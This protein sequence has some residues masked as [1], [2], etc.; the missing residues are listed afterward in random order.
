[1]ILKSQSMWF[2]M[3]AMMETAQIWTRDKIENNDTSL[4]INPSAPLIIQVGDFGYE[5]QSC[6][7]DG[8]HEGFVIMCKPDPVCEWRGLECIKLKEKNA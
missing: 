3:E 6:G 5:V 7:G 1:M 2:V 4:N 8:D